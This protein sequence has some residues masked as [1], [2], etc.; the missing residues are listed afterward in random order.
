MS[1]LNPKTLYK[2]GMDRSLDRRLKEYRNC[3]IWQGK[4]TSNA[5]TDDEVDMHA[6]L[7]RKERQTP[8]KMTYG[9]VSTLMV[10]PS[11]KR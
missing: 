1:G 4:G 5:L 9:N 6:G 8:W 7:W 11:L 3:R 10:E 2:E